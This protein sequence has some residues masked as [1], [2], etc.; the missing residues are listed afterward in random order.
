MLWLLTDC[1]SGTY[2]QGCGKDCS[3]YCEE[4]NVCNNVDGTCECIAGYQPG[5]CDEGKYETQLYNVHITFNNSF[6][7]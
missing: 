2:G 5:T 3:A 4:A 1:T 7:K 6:Y